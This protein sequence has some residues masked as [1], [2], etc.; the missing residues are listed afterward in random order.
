MNFEIYIKPE[1]F[2]KKK[3]KSAN[4]LFIR[5][6]H[7]YGFTRQVLYSQVRFLYN[8]GDKTCLYRKESQYYDT[9]YY[10]I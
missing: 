2:M 7:I 1:I 5:F 3:K 10:A 9:Q 8:I 6:A 4:P